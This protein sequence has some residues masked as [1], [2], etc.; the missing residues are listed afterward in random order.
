MNAADGS[1]GG[2]MVALLVA[3]ALATQAQASNAAD[4][5]CYDRAVVGHFQHADNFVG[6]DH[7]VQAQPGEVMVGGRWDVDID[8]DKVFVGDPK[9][10]TMKA[11]VVLT[12]LFTPGAKLLL[13]LKKGPVEPDK[14]NT[15]R[16]WNGRF[17][18]R[19]STARP[20][21]VVF[22]QMKSGGFD[23]GDPSI[24]PRCSKS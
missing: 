11:R 19:P 12:D 23:P 18:P 9:P 21:S 13:L 4:E 8:V 10:T 17:I 20:W 22:L 24:P 16:E 2:S 1:A 3:A 14:D 5:V 7:F 6:L 15:V